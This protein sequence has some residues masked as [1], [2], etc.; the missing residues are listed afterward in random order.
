M[1]LYELRDTPPWEWPEDAGDVFL[2]YLRDE[3][4]DESDRLLAAEMGGDYVVVNDELA[5]ALLDIVRNEAEPEELRARAAISLGICLEAASDSSLDDIEDSPITEAVFNE[6]QD[7]FHKLY[8]DT[9]V[10]KLVR[11]RILEASVRAPQDWHPDAIRDAYASFDEEWKLTAVFGMGWVRGFEK[12][13][14]EALESQDEDILYEAV[15]AAGN[16]QLKSAWSPLVKLLSKRHVDRDV[17]LA[18]I[19]AIVEIDP[20][21]AEGVLLKLVDSK[22]E[23]ISQAALDAL[24]TASGLADF[25]DDWDEEDEDLGDL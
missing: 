11:R 20:K 9:G 18:A 7:T 13:I 25:S 2:V 17:L 16:W 6:I 4:A 15:S 1:D 14:L 3:Q 8:S 10:P 19:E 24:S 23:E 12:Q 5:L 21:E 22:D